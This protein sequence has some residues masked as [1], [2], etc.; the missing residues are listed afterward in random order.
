MNR[1]LGGAILSLILLMPSV[2]E[3]TEVGIWR[4]DEGGGTTFADDSPSSNHG[5]SVESIPGVT[6][7]PVGPHG[8]AI[9][10]AAPGGRVLIP[11]ASSLDLQD[12]ITLTAWVRPAELKTQY[13]VKKGVFGESDGYE[14]ALS[15]S[16]VAFARFNQATSG[17]AYKIFSTSQYP[18]DGQTWIHLSV[19]FDGQTLRLYVDG[20]LETELAAPGLSIGTNAN[21]LSI[22]AEDDGGGWLHGAVDDVH[23]YARALSREDI[24]SIIATG[25]RL[26]DADD[27]GVPD[28]ADAFPDD[29]SETLDFDGDGIGDNQDPDDDAD[30][31]PDGWE[32]SHGFDPFDS[33][34]ATQD[35][36]GDGLSNLFEYERGL[37]PLVVEA[38]RIGSWRFDEQSG[39]VASD[40]SEFGNH[41]D[42]VGASWGPGGGSPPPPPTGSPLEGTVPTRKGQSLLGRVIV[43]GHAL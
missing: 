41:G 40:D 42:L 33:T 14:L 3:A 34:D 26:P 20:V 29:P 5:F 43:L 18:T 35:A 13:I 37:D 21:D 32:L 6:T 19:S 10:F 16:G 24:E 31:L 8:G 38:L 39:V 25:S 17:N 2:A 36:D 23:V 1:L 28:A 9:A 4:F 27:D 30:G 11:D 7:F 22:G 12:A 15:S